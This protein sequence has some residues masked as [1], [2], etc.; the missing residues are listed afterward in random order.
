[1]ILLVGDGRR[2]DVVHA[3]AQVEPLLRE[4]TDAVVVDLDQTFDPA[5]KKPQLVINF[6]G[7][8]SILR[9]AGRLGLNQVPLL[10][11][12]FGRFGFLAEYELPELLL[13][14]KDAVAGR[15]PTRQSLLLRVT[16]ESPA[17]RAERFV[18]NDVVM[19][20]APNNRMAHVYALHDGEELADYYGDGLI[21]STPIGSTAYNLAA[22]GALLHPMLDALILT[23][24]CPHS[25][26]LRPM[27]IPASGKLELVLKGDDVI[28]ITMDG[29]GTT[30]LKG[31][32]RVVIE[33]S[34]V[35]M[36]LVA[37]PERSYY[38]TLRLRFHWAKRS[39]V[40]R[41]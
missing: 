29:E 9:I 22:G 7:D 4:L 40:S 8:G 30:E 23:P 13:R 19:Q 31:G 25:L 34:P 15:L 33:R 14:V 5:V 20:R 16:V 39:T 37:H 2:A 36:T 38:G 27:V 10:G 28:S 41:P 35:P 17:G 11:V 18:V 3:I 21:V 1:M 32:D 24:M 26:T 6:G 12:N